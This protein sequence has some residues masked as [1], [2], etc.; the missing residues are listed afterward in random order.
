[1]SGRLCAKVACIARSTLDHSARVHVCIH[2]CAHRTFRC[3]CS[4]GCGSRR[5][6]AK[7]ALRAVGP[8]FVDMRTDAATVSFALSKLSFNRRV[9]MQVRRS[10]MCQWQHPH[11]PRQL[12]LTMQRARAKTTSIFLTWVRASTFGLHGCVYAHERRRWPRC[13][14]TC[15]GSTEY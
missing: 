2:V 9:K 12:G 15:L 6:R 10:R 1:M 3:T 13:W 8:V 7:A 14:R 5:G 11:G 4:G